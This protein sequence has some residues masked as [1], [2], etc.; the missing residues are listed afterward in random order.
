MQNL[1]NKLTDYL[2]S[3]RDNPPVSVFSCVNGNSFLDWKLAQ[4]G[5]YNIARVVGAYAMTK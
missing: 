1:N 3:I 2:N 4:N 5:E